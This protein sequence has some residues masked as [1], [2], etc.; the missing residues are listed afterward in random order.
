MSQANGAKSKPPYLP[1]SRTAGYAVLVALCFEE[2]RSG[3]TTM[4]TKEQIADLAYPKWTDTE[5]IKKVENRKDKGKS[6]FYD[7]W[8]SVKTT[9]MDKHGLVEKIHRKPSVGRKMEK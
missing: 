6:D 1:R 4:W 7:G 5:I 9:L 2:E 8:S 3:G